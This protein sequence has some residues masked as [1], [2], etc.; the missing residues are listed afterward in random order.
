M[1]WFSKKVDAVDTEAIKAEAQKAYDAV[2]AGSKQVADSLGNHID[3]LVKHPVFGKYSVQCITLTI[4]GTL[5]VAY[6]AGVL[7]L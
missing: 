3:P 2:V 5:A 4:L 6:L 1:G 7:I